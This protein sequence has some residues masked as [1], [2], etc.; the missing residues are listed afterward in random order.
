[1]SETEIARSIF[2]LP[3]KDDQ[4]AHSGPESGD[5]LLSRVRGGDREAFD[6]LYRRLAPLVHG[7]LLAR[8]PPSEVDD[9]VQDVFVAA[10]RN[11][12]SLRDDSAVSAWIGSI[13]R[14]RAA[15]FFRRSKPTQELAEEIRAG[16]RPLVEAREALAAIRGLPKAYNETLILRLV[17]GM[18]GPEI[19][20]ATGMTPDSV[21]VNLHRGMKLL[22]KRMGIRE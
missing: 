20:E 17:E 7:I 5:P 10:F 2:V 15:E 1:M 4:A 11:I 22:R 16:E 18:T 9:L 21:R 13:A 19:A 14:R 12:G 3:R 6:E 8:V